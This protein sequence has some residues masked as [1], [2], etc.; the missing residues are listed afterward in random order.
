MESSWLRLFT[1]ICWGS[2]NRK[3]A[4]N[5]KSEENVSNSK[6][7]QF[8]ACILH[9]IN[10]TDTSR[11]DSFRFASGISRNLFK[12]SIEC[13]FWEILD[14][15]R[16]RAKKRT[17]RMAGIL[18]WILLLPYCSMFVVC[19]GIH[20]N[21]VRTSSMF[22]SSFFYLVFVHYKILSILFNINPFAQEDGVRFRT[23]HHT[24]PTSLT[25]NDENCFVAITL[26][27]PH[28]YTFPQH[29]R[30]NAESQQQ[31]IRSAKALWRSRSRNLSLIL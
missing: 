10:R 31:P 23:V 2:S 16:I 22:L 4:I 9:T 1:F 27:L 30:R 19:A 12:T 18:N 20:Y 24:T 6:L 17:L 26:P 5:P 7:Q 14:S 21:F 25:A 8:I 29:Q 3:Q 13:S 15:T 11:F 28:T